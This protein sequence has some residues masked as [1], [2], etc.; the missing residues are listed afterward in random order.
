MDSPT[1]VPYHEKIQGLDSSPVL[2]QQG[3]RGVLE[4]FLTSLGLRLS[5]SLPICKMEHLPLPHDITGRGGIQ[6]LVRTQL[7]MFC[8]PPM[9]PV[10]EPSRCRVKLQGPENSREEAVWA[11]SACVTV[12]S[13]T[14]D[15]WG[16]QAVS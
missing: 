8:I 11:P 14:S 10:L 9:G 12:T 4:K 15:H 7:S 1:I 13:L 2:P 3:E 16:V 5:L 6:V